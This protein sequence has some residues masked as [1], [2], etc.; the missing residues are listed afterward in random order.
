MTQPMQ[1][2][3]TETTTTAVVS[4]T[5]LLTSKTPNAAQQMMETR[6][7]AKCSLLR[8][9]LRAFFSLGRQQV[10]FLQYWESVKESEGMSEDTTL[11][12]Y[13]GTT[14]EESEGMTAPKLT[15]HFH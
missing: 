2:Q 10:L 3:P 5:I 8:A 12:E 7:A 11:V 6:R 15:I 1:A 9:I 13:E 4:A 14:P